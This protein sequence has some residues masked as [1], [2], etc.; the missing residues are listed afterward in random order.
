MTAE[1]ER[2][3]LEVSYRRERGGGRGG[4]TEESNRRD[5][6]GSQVRRWKDF[7]GIK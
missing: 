3:G 7:A 4:S 2:V 5:V 6:E 1:E